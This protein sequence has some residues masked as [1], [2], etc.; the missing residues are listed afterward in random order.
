MGFIHP[1]WCRISSIVWYIWNPSIMTKLGEFQIRHHTFEKGIPALYYDKNSPSFVM[2]WVTVLFRPCPTNY[3]WW[4]KSCTSWYGKFPIN[5]RVLYI[6]R[7]AGFLPSTVWMREVLDSPQGVLKDEWVTCYLHPKQTKIWWFYGNSISHLW[8]LLP[9]SINF[10]S[11]YIYIYIYI[12]VR[13]LT[14]PPT[15]RY[16]WWM[17]FLLVRWDVLV[18]WRVHY[19]SAGVWTPIIST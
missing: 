18:F 5:Y 2:Y 1:T 16:F 11:I 7:G 19:T 12:C 6:P 3:C 14:Y 15:I 9:I 17:I 10:F 8:I 13:E 4:L